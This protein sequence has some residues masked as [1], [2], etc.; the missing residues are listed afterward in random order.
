VSLTREMLRLLAAVNARG[1]VDVSLA[2][3]SGL[4]HR[5]RF[6]LHRRFVA[7]VGETPKGYTSRVRLTRAAAELLATD[8][9]ISVIAD[10]HGYASHEVFTRA[11]TRQFG[12]SPSRYRARGVHAE[13]DPAARIHA[14]TV[15]SVAPCVGLYRRDSR[16]RSML[17]P[18]V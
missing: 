18:V 7:A 1:R 6:S 13:D 17:V 2:A 11:F 15:A 16:E 8:R 14:A 12:L 4:A 5:S 9:P 3:L 10:R